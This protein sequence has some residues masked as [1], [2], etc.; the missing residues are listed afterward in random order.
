[1][2][3]TSERV[4]VQNTHNYKLTCILCLASFLKRRFSWQQFEKEE[5]A[6]L[7]GSGKDDPRRQTFGMSNTEGLA[8]LMA[9]RW[10]SALTLMT[11]YRIGVSR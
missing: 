2:F 11:S 7:S 9:V 10:T 4:Y 6:G 3:M 8:S 1:M 5:S